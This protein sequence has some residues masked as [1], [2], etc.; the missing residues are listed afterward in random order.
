MHKKGCQANFWQPFHLLLFALIV[1]FC[2][3]CK[4]IHHGKRKKS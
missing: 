2:I 3:F 1:L 4:I